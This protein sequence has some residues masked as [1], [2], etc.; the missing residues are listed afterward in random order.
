MSMIRKKIFYS[1]SKIAGL[2]LKYIRNVGNGVKKCEFLNK[3]D[4]K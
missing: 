3:S 1:K 2:Y 4:Y